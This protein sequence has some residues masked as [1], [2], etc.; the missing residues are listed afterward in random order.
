MEIQN[1]DNEIDLDQSHQD[2]RVEVKL[3]NA[4]ELRSNEVKIACNRTKDTFEATF[5]CQLKNEDSSKKWVQYDNPKSVIMNI[6][7]KGIP[8]CNISEQ[9]VDI[10]QNQNTKEFITVC[11]KRL[12]SL[13]EIGKIND[14]NRS[15]HY[16]IFKSNYSE[17]K[18]VCEK[19][20]NIQEML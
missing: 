14:G 10:S 20:L 18:S 9:T 1:D 2:W 15:I 17:Q 3:F 4:I 5:I 7:Y 12:N 8:I 16:V 11:T 19:A 13:A 6:S